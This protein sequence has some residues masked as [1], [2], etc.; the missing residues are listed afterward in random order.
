MKR[1]ELLKL[2]DMFISKNILFNQN[3]RSGYNKNNPFSFNVNI[4]N[5]LPC[6]I[7]PGK[8][9]VSRAF[10]NL[11]AKLPELGGNN[12]VLIA[13]PEIVSF[14]LNEESDFIF[15]GSDGIFDSLSNA[16]II[17]IIWESFNSN[18][19]GNTVY[20][21]AGITTD[22]IMKMALNGKSKDNV[23]AIFVCFDNF[24]QNYFEE[25]FHYIIHSNVNCLSESNILK[26]NCENLD[27]F[28]LLI[29]KELNLLK[30]E[31]DNEETNS[32]DVG[33]GRRSVIKSRRRTVNGNV[34]GQGVAKRNS[35]F[36]SLFIEK[37]KQRMSLNFP[38]V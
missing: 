33:V 21:H 3:F 14:K 24:R 13:E 8:L 1:I 23:S 15:L 20:K 2:E 12:R 17:E 28:D 4:N 22:L 5:N 30:E 10:G 9:T 7:F 16:K 34:Y 6:R 38:K 26:K 25:K 31:S 27:F 35:N 37:L 36:P 32:G 18:I 29:N 11:E 19:K